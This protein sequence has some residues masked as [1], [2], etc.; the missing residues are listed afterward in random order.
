MV[1]VKITQTFW[2]AFPRIRF[3]LPG[4]QF[5]CI[6][7]L[8]S[9]FYFMSYISL[10][11]QI[12]LQRIAPLCGLAISFA[13]FTFLTSSVSVNAQEKVPVGREISFLNFMLQ[14]KDLDLPEDFV[15]RVDGGSLKVVLSTLGVD[16]RKSA[17]SKV[18]VAL[19]DE[20]GNEDQVETDASGIAE[21]KNVKANKLHALLVND[22]EYHA[23][24]PVL[25]VSAD[26][27]DRDNIQ[28]TDIRLTAIPADRDEILTSLARNIVPSRTAGDLYNANNY[29]SSGQSL[30]QVRLSDDNTLSGRILIPDKDLSSQLRYANITVYQDRK[31]VAQTTASTDD[32]SFQLP[33]LRAGSYGLIAAGPSGY[34]AFA[35]EVLEPAAQLPPPNEGAK[36]PVAFNMAAPAPGLVVFMIPPK[37]INAIV[38]RISQSYNRSN[39]S[40]AGTPT[41]PSFAGGGGGFGGM[42]GGIGGGTAGAT[43]GVAGGTAGAAGG[44]GGIG[45][46]AGIA[47]VAAVAGIAANTNNNTGNNLPVSP[48]VQ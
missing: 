14:S 31:A 3:D 47:G 19:L 44:L 29:R 32:G 38:Q 12:S 6:L 2:K 40:P 16:Q 33:N 37:M 24:I 36:L 5:L 48:I 23:A 9:R 25:P 43:G 22:A 42:G 4:I 30:Y 11:H 41:F 20:N 18:L 13:S 35:F 34:S 8:F 21:F 26:K 28:A 17:K 10:L 39:S 46:L 15:A 1:F 7:G 27:A 45:G